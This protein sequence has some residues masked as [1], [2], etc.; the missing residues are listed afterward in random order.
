MICIHTLKSCAHVTR[1]HCL[2]YKFFS[3]SCMAPLM[4]AAHLGYGD[5]VR[6]L[7]KARALVNIR[8]EV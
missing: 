3:Q 8:D 5:I 4:A 6:I 2:Y 7:I 1:A